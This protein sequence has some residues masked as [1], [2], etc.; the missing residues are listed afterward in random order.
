MDGTRDV[1]IRR[2]ITKDTIP[3]KDFMDFVSSDNPSTKFKFVV[4]KQ[5]EDPSQYPKHL[6]NSNYFPSRNI[7]IP[8]NK[9]MVL[10]NGIV[11]PKDAD[12]IE[13]NLYIEIGGSY[14][15]KNRF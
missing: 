8:V 6:L 3:I 13:D 5:G 1:I 4:E 14:L 10:K 15:Y 7:S 9:D 11:K 2:E 12:K